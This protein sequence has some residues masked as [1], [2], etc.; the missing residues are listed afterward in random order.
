M[1]YELAS[2]CVPYH[3]HHFDFNFQLQ[4]AIRSGLRPSEGI[5]TSTPSPFLVLMNQAWNPDPSQR[6]T[7][8]ILVSFFEAMFLQM[9]SLAL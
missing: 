2:S 4:E 5:S 1:M 7:F 6:P 8:H 3:E 9:Q